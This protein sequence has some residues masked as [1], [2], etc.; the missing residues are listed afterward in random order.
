MAFP[1]MPLMNLMTSSLVPEVFLLKPGSIRRDGSGNIL[2]A[3]SSVSLIIFGKRRIIV[4]TGQK[5][6][7]KWILNSLAKL[8]LQPEDIDTIVNT[9]SHADHCANNYLFSRANIL[10][11]KGEE[12]I[13]PG[14]QVIDTPGHSLDSI[15][16]VVETRTVECISEMKALTGL[17]MIV[18]MAG[19]ALPTLGNFQKNIPPAL[20]VDR[21]LAV[22]SMEKIIGLA[23]VVVPGHDMPFLPK[24]LTPLG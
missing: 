5:G 23:D 22:L 3:R 8:D 19:D 21:D 7:E 20:H 4:D 17:M 9:H 24:K 11:A 13:V 16:V 14:V 2:D 12:K 6:D 15:S 1:K 18:V 10:A